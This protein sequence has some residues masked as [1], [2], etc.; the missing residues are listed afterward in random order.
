[1]SNQSASVSFESLLESALLR[2]E[3]KTGVT[4]S[5][6]PLATQ[7]QSCNSVEDFNNLLQEK[8]KDVRESER[9]TKSM[10]T[11]VSILTPLSS[12]VSIPHAAGLVCYKALMA[13]SYP[14]LFTGLSTC[15]SHTGLS[16]CLT[17]RMCHSLVLCRFL[18]TP[19][20]N[21]SAKGEIS[22]F[23]AL[24]DWLESIENFIGRLSI[25]TNKTLSPAVVEIVVKTMEELISTL[26]LVTRKLKEGKRG[27]FVLAY[28]VSPYSARRRQT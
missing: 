7:L 17:P 2:Y 18:V 13:A 19:K 15:E 9:I 6:H 26:A 28:Y 10:K 12:A 11:I 1:M 5:K 24:V 21:Q 22:N 3:K 25:Y 4:L 23:N 16:R 20:M 27:G 14:D 8:A